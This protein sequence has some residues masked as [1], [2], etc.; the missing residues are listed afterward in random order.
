MSAVRR[1]YQKKYRPKQGSDVDAEIDAQLPAHQAASKGEIISLVKAIQHDPSSLEL[2]DSEG[3][4]P[5][6]HAVKAKEMEAV[7]QIIKMGGNIN[8]QDRHGRT[9]LALATYQGWFE[10][11]IYLLRKGAKQSIAEKSGRTPLH[12]STYDKDVRIIGALLQ[13]LSKEEVA[14]HDNERMTALHWAAFHNR[15]EHLQLLLMSGANMYS[16]DIDGKTPLHWAAEKGSVECCHLLLQCCKGPKLANQLDNSSKNAA[17]YAAAAGHYLLLRELA[18]VEGMDL[19][20]EDPDDRTPLHWAAAMGHTQCVSVLLNMGVTPNPLDMEGG[21]PLDYAK[22]TGHKDCV[23]LLEE[24]MGIRPSSHQNRRPKVKKSESTRNP[25]GKLKELFR[26]RSKKI[27]ST[28]TSDATS[29]SIE[30]RSFDKYSGTASMSNSERSLKDLTRREE[31]APGAQS[32]TREGQAPPQGA[33]A[34][35]AVPKIVLSTYDEKEEDQGLLKQRKNR[36]KR[37]KKKRSRQTSRTATTTFEENYDLHS[38]YNINKGNNH[39]DNH[40]IGVSISTSNLL[41][42]VMSARMS[43]LPPSPIPQDLPKTPP[44][45]KSSKDLAPLRVPQIKSPGPQAYSQQSSENQEG[46]LSPPYGSPPYRNMEGNLSSP[47]PQLAQ[48]HLHRQF[49][50]DSRPPQQVSSPWLQVKPASGYLYERQLSGS[51]QDSSTHGGTDQTDFLSVS[52]GQRSRLS[53]I[54]QGSISGHRSAL[55][56]A[57]SDVSV[58]LTS[59]TPTHYGSPKAAVSFMGSQSPTQVSQMEKRTMDRRIHSLLH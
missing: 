10:G 14:V 38:G 31:R 46:S 15:P 28:P 4:T 56:S 55:S 17:H 13:T 9:P 30:M 8:T 16:Q 20:A 29:D 26:P 53:S 33:T 5:L 57:R 50:A 32:Q 58:R 49:K 3:L 19:E 11:V 44:P 41:P 52:S 51:S 6:A 40:P 39:H 12:A 35:V 7:K 22:Q 25:F 42:P 18:S 21:T 36:S 47:V 45:R 23:R 54:S 43:P 27:S 37:P 48:E 34:A 2:E 59:I 24:K 1:G